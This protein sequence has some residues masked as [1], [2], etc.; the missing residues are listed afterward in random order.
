M[1]RQRRARDELCLPCHERIDPDRREEAPPADRGLFWDANWLFVRGM[2]HPA[3]RPG[4]GFRDP[5]LTTGE[6][7]ELLAWLHGVLAG[8]VASA[9]LDEG[10]RLEFTEP[11]LAFGLVSREA[12]AVLIRVVLSHEGLGAQAAGLEAMG[13]YELVLAVPEGELELAAAEWARQ[14]AAHPVR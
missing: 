7:R 4:W 13:R 9:M 14:V 5:C 10:E 6:A 12:E 8:D 2:V 3:D 1:S 11:V